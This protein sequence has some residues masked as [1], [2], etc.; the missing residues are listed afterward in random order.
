MVTFLA[1]VAAGIVLL[2][3][4]AGCA[5]HLTKPGSLPAALRAHRIVP[6]ALVPAVAR[7]V[8]AAEGLL[9]AGGAAL[10]VAGH[11][12]GL[13]SVLAAAALLC[14]GYAAYSRHA[15]AAGR[16]GSPCGCSRTEV[17]LSGWVAGR[18]L[19]LALLAA[20]AAALTA[21]GAQPP[22]GAAQWAVVVLAAAASTALLW[23]LPAAMHQPAPPRPAPG[24]HA[25]HR[26][27]VL[28]GGT[29]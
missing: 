17:P 18:A 15:L 24:P 1:P 26:P 25:R 21:A 14:A 28:P 10:L 7:A 4:L 3:L 16:A 20:A 29:P 11:R 6:D 23:S 5:A 27:A 9:G 12:A 13:A 19:A 2:S 8:P 22:A